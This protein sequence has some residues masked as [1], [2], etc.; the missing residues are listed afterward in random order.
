[1]SFHL[2]TPSLK[3]CVRLSALLLLFAASSGG[4]VL[5]AQEAPRRIEFERGSST[6]EVAGT[7]VGRN[8]R[9]EYIFSSRTGRTLDVQVTSGEVGFTLQA[10]DGTPL[11]PP[12]TGWRPGQLAGGMVLVLPHRG[13]YRISVAP[14]RRT[15]RGGTLPYTLRLTLTDEGQSADDATTGD[16][17][18]SYEHAYNNLMALSSFH[19]VLTAERQPNQFGGPQRLRAEGDY[20]AR[21]R[22][23]RYTLSTSA[24]SEELDGEWV[25]LNATNTSY[26]LMSGGW[27]RQGLSII[28]TTDSSIEVMRKAMAPARPDLGRNEPPPLVGTETIEGQ[29]CSHYSFTVPAGRPLV[30]TYDAYLNARGDFIRLDSLDAVYRYSVL[31]SRQNQPVRISAPN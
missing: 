5:R 26:H 15:G 30:G 6:A 4:S 9:D 31:I 19:F 25:K 11:G 14:L 18:I 20:D 1:M 13:D 10:P 21:S 24:A 27:R 22:A 3:R 17:T 8:A 12:D 2:Q 16:P 29:A 28:D 7:L 23:W